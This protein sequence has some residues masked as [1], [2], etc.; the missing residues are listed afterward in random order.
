MLLLDQLNLPVETH[1][2]VTLDFSEVK[3][4]PPSSLLML[5]ACH[6]SKRLHLCN[7]I[8]HL[9]K[10]LEGHDDTRSQSLHISGETSPS[11]LSCRMWVSQTAVIQFS[12]L[13]PVLNQR[14]HWDTVT[15][16]SCIQNIQIQR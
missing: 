3:Q 15:F 12:C 2:L 9:D 14:S 10:W 16:H 1:Q 4:V 8:L 11:S 13:L 7:E 6:C 5:P